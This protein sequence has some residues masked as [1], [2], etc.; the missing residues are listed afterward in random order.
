MSHAL[1]WGLSSIS[2]AVPTSGAAIGAVSLRRNGCSSMMLCGGGRGRQV[3]GEHDQRGDQ[4]R[5]PAHAA[6]STIAAINAITTWLTRS[7]S[8]KTS[9]SSCMRPRCAISHM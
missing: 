9:G 4:R 7:R 1:I 8:A 5:A 3:G 6:I 2:S